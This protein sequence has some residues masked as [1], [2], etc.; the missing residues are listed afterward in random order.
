M[1]RNLL[2][3]CHFERSEECASLPRRRLRQGATA[4]R[5]DQIAAENAPRVA[6]RDRPARVRGPVE[7]QGGSGSEAVQRP[8]KSIFFADV[9]LL[10]CVDYEEF[11][12]QQFTFVNS[13]EH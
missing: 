12:A 13:R 6:F 11:L 9:C 8:G 5:G 1:A 2:W 4:R 3:I 10:F 7:V